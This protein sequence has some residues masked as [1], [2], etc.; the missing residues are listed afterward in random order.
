MRNWSAGWTCISV[1]RSLPMSF[2]SSI[3]PSDRKFGLFRDILL[4]FPPQQLLNGAMLVLFH[5]LNL[6]LPFDQPGICLNQFNSI[7][8]HRVMLVALVVLFFDFGATRKQTFDT[9]YLTS[10]RY[11][12][13]GSFSLSR[14]QMEV[15]TDLER[16]IMKVHFLEC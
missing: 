13:Q 8:L 16:L 14:L 9:T 5:E 4:I 12:M 1:G 3:G 2:T 6:N 15:C 10:S 7:E 11:Q